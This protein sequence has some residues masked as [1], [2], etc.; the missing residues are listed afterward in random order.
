MNELLLFGKNYVE[1][2]TFIV[3][4][5]PHKGNNFTKDLGKVFRRM[6]DIGR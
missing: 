1:Q 3:S 4:S 5:W 2:S 6:P